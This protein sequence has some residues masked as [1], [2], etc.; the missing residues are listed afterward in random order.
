VF[1]ED[2]GSWHPRTPLELRDGA[3]LWFGCVP[4]WNAFNRLSR[5]RDYTSMGGPLPIKYRDLMDEVRRIKWR[6]DEEAESLIVA[7]DD[8]F[9][10]IAHAQMK[11][12]ADD[13]Q[14]N[15][16]QA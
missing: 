11:A 7:I 12:T 15:Q 2:D 4:I 8:V 6:D 5:G 1:T 16:D 3:T 14:R 9:L 13:N 10:S